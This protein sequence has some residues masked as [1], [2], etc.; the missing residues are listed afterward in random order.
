MRIRTPSTTYAVETMS[1][2]RSLSTPHAMRRLAA[3]E[4]AR[5][6]L[7]VENASGAH[8]GRQF[9][10]AGGTLEFRFDPETP[11]GLRRSWWFGWIRHTIWMF[12]MSRSAQLNRCKTIPNTSFQ[13]TLPRRV[14]SAELGPF[15]RERSESDPHSRFH[16]WLR[17]LFLVALI[18]LFTI[19]PK[20][21]PRRSTLGLSSLPD[22]SLFWPASAV[23]G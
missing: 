13:R 1:C 22:F 16:P 4:D 15:G 11:R 14:R 10:V 19:L 12:V 21:L 2:E 7:R 20:P 17:P 8:C 6:A 3:L 9:D 18:R 5:R 23:F